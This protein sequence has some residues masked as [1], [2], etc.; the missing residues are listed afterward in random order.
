MTTAIPP[1]SYPEWRTGKFDRPEDAAYSFGY[2]LILHC[3][4]EAMA[5]LPA[6]ASPEL[7][8]AVEKAVDAALHNVCDM[9]EGFW[10]LEAG[11]N[12][13][14]SL[15][16]GVQVRDSENQVIEMQEISPCKLDL[17]IGYWKWAQE[18][19]FR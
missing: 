3:R 8:A 1:R 19:A 16:L 15:A 12:H 7:A 10:P 5:T 14:I 11:P 6:D 17:P 13:R 4:E 18:R 9:L 2:H